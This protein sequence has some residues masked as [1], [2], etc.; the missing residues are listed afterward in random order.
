[1]G[2]SQSSKRSVY[3]LRPFLLTQFGLLQC[4]TYTFK[5]PWGPVI[6]SFSRTPRSWTI[7]RGILRFLWYLEIYFL[8]LKVL[9]KKKRQESLGVSFAQCHLCRPTGQWLPFLSVFA[10]NTCWK[11]H[12]GIHWDLSAKSDNYLMSTPLAMIF[13]MWKHL[14]TGNRV[15]LWCLVMVVSKHTLCFSS[16]FLS[17]RARTKILSFVSLGFLVVGAPSGLTNHWVTQIQIRK[18]ANTREECPF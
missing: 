15:V 11:V 4:G 16:W 17:V 5:P 3:V 12:L 18:F 9:T 13:S 7:L 14:Q 8:C 2:P 1:M 6:S 10:W